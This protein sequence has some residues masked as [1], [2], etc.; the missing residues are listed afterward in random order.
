MACAKPKEVKVKQKKVPDPGV[1]TTELLEQAIV[2]LQENGRVEVP[3]DEILPPPLDPALR[4]I[5]FQWGEVPQG[6]ARYR[7]HFEPLPA[8]DIEDEDDDDE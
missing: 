3:P 6:A 4:R 2:A 7:F 5:E 1:L 8:A